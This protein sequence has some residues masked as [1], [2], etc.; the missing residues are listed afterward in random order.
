MRIDSLQKFYFVAKRAIRSIEQIKFFCIVF[1]PARYTRDTIWF[2]RKTKNSY[3]WL[4]KYF[5]PCILSIPENSSILIGILNPTPIISEKYPGLWNINPT[6]Y[7]S[8]SETR[9]FGRATSFVFNP[10]TNSR[11]HNSLTT[12]NPETKAPDVDCN[13]VVRNALFTGVLMPNG[14][15]ANQEI[16]LP[17]SLPPCLED[18][19][20]FQYEDQVHLIGTWTTQELDGHHFVIKQSI[21]IFAT[22]T[23]IFRFLNSPFGLTMEKNWVPIEVIKDK[24][25][26]F[27]SSQPSRVL[28][29]DLRST[30]TKVRSIRSHPLKIDFHGRSQFVKIP[31]GN[32]IR[33]ASLRMPIKDFGLVHFSFLLEH[34]QEYEVIRI[35]RPFLFGTPGFEICNGLQLSSESQMIFSWGCNDRAS[36]FAKVPL[37]ELM[38]WLENNE[39]VVKNFKSYS[40]KSLRRIFLEIEAAHLCECKTVVGM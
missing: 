30:E 29:I 20:A 15:L 9:I 12:T 13:S 39:L 27:Y 14:K 10:R 23:K 40:W 36:Y 2:H 16:L 5:D 35:S 34:N 11:G 28:E 8:D 26:V 31:S 24:L 33:V 22:V 4:A 25:M 17:E 3:K 6:V 38:H 18:V 32:F 7:C 21:A 1:Y 19:R 37:P